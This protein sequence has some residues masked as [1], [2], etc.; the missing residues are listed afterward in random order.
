MEAKALPEI[1]RE[2]IPRIEAL[3]PEARKMFIRILISVV[4]PAPFGPTSAW[5][6]PWGTEKLSPSK[7]WTRPNRLVKASVSIGF[8]LAL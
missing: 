8:T 5:T 7:A 1:F 2:S 4:F 6:A 3:P